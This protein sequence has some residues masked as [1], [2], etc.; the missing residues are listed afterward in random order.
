[1]WNYKQSLKHKTTI[2]VNRILRKKITSVLEFS[3]SHKFRNINFKNQVLWHALKP[4]T[5]GY[6]QGKGG[7]ISHKQIPA[8]TSCPQDSLSLIQNQSVDLNFLLPW[9]INSHYNVHIN[10]YSI[11]INWWV[12]EKR[13]K[14]NKFSCCLASGTLSNQ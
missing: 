7:K 14:E 2:V 10:N 1:M 11:L 4:R 9:K 13:K 8:I 3:S 5:P 12:Y 6:N